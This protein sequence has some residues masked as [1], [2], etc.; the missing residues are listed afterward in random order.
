MI[1]DVRRLTLEEIV[2][3]VSSRRWLCISIV[4][5]F[6]LGGVLLAYLSPKIYRAEALLAP[7]RDVSADAGGSSMLGSLGSFA[8]LSGL[9]NQ[10]QTL[11]DEA[12]A[13][14]RSRAFLQKFIDDEQL[15]P[16]LY[17][18][19]WDPVRRAWKPGIGPVPTSSRAWK[20][21]RDDVIRIEDV[22][23]KEM[24]KV[25]VEW[26]DPKLPAIW[27]TSLIE[28]LN[29]EM[30]TR[31]IKEATEVLQFL[32]QRVEQTDAVEIRAALFRLS[33]TQLRR[34]AM[35]SVRQDYAF[36]VLDS[37]FPS[38]L[39]Q[40]VRPRRVILLALSIIL[41]FAAALFI[42]VVAPRK[43]VQA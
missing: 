17:K 21:L 30:R 10:G 39:D 18:E 40:F 4:F 43:K 38:E 3:R 35:A 15:L 26:G 11:T 14:L 13:I 29:L 32:R 2:Q 6:V 36:R 34:V 25:S 37:P 42:A 33:E 28:R 41:G 20:K 31:E 24:Q 19:H 12:I 23:G 22:P 9:L 16:K 27:L 7:N 1:D 5:A 8:S